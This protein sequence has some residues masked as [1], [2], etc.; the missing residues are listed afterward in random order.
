MSC[1][2]AQRQEARAGAVVAEYESLQQQQLAQLHRAA[3]ELGSSARLSEAQQQLGQMEATLEAADREHAARV[4]SILGKLQVRHH[5]YTSA[6]LSTV[7]IISKL[8]TAYA[9]RNQVV[10]VVVGRIPACRHVDIYCVCVC[11]CANLCCAAFSCAG[12]A[13][14][15]SQGVEGGLSHRATL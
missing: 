7:D 6:A 2:F 11:V 15:I 1:R 5:M 9:L 12:S 3:A 13:C 14:R 10:R 8:S 4:A